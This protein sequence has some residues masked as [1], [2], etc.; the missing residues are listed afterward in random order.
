MGRPR[1]R[2]AAAADDK[3][4]PSRANRAYLRPHRITAVIS[5]KADQAVNRK[6]KGRAG[7]R[8]VSHHTV[9]YKTRNTVERCI[10]R[11]KEWRGPATR[12]DKT[13]DSGHTSIHLH[14]T[15]IRLRSPPAFHD[16]AS[17]HALTPVAPNQGPLKPPARTRELRISTIVFTPL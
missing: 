6:K 11:F 7:G 9:L 13:P 2:P 14:G 1:T 3:V 17:Q 15:T 8:P 4:R 10:N 5:G 12:Y 16:Q